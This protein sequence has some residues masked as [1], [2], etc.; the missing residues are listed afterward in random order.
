MSIQPCVFCDKGIPLFFIIM[1]QGVFHCTYSRINIFELPVTNNFSRHT[2]HWRIHGKK[3]QVTSEKSEDKWRKSSSQQFLHQNLIRV[4]SLS[5]GNKLIH[6]LNKLLYDLNMEH[7]IIIR[8]SPKM[9]F[10][11]NKLKKPLR[12][13]FHAPILLT[14]SRVNQMYLVL[15]RLWENSWNIVILCGS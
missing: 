4:L 8:N 14:W 6:N 2:S 13:C 3:H 1:K 7:N 15:T 11:A 9:K 5:Q 12:D 10:T